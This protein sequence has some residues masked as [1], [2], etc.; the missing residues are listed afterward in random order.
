V[1]RHELR[2]TRWEDI[3]PNWQ[4]MDFVFAYAAPSTPQ[5][6]LFSTIKLRQAGFQDCLDT[7]AMFVELFDDMRRRRLIPA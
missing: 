1:A 5:P 3:S 7:E 6:S 2:P 4:F